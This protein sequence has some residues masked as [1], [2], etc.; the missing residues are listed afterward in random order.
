MSL[1]EAEGL[2]GIARVVSAAAADPENVTLKSEA[3]RANAELISHFPFGPPALRDSTFVALSQTV[4][5]IL[6]NAWFALIE[7]PDEWRLLHR[8]PAVLDHAVEELLRYAGLVRTLYRT[9]TEDVNLNGAPIRSGDVLILRIVEANR[10]PGRF[11]CAHELDVLR[12]DGGHLA[13]GAG[14]HACVGAPL[15]RM[16]VQSMT[17]PLIRRFAS[18]ILARPVEWQGGSTFRSPDSLW[19]R[20]SE[21]FA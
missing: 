17:R 12:Q 2:S 8:Q 21:D 3:E 5:C 6:G 11:A 18:A 14:F 9:A 7:H 20:L 13:L 10:D 16:A 15:I 1:R 19:V 4:R